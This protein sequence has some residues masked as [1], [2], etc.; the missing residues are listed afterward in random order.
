MTCTE[1]GSRSEDTGDFCTECGAPLRVDRDTSERPVSR[2]TPVKEMVGSERSEWIDS[3]WGS[4][5]RP[6]R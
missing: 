3:V 1:C 5:T 2:P 4:T 6:G